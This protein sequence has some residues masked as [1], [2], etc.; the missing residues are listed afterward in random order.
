MARSLPYGP[1]LTCP[2]CRSKLAT[3]VTF[4]DGLQ[5]EAYKGHAIIF[6]G[7]GYVGLCIQGLLAE[8]R[9]LQEA[10]G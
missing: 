6:D 10:A 2:K 1:S 9:R 7:T 5:D 3:S 8:D 4:P